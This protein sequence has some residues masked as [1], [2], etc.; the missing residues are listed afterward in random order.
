MF[1]R[2]W[3]A[4][5]IGLALSSAALA[6]PIVIKF[7]LVVSEDTPKGKGALLFQRLVDERLAG[8]VKVEVYANSSLY[9]DADKVEALRNNDIQMI[10][11]PLTKYQQYSPQL[12]LFDLP[13]LFDNLKSVERFQQRATGRKLLRSMEQHNITGLAYWHNGMKQLA[14][15]RVIRA[16]DD[17]QGL[18]F[19][20]QPSPV[21]EAQFNALGATAKAVPFIKVYDALASNALQGTEDAW[22]N[23]YS[24]QLH[25][26][27]SSITESEHGVLDYMLVS[28][29]R[30]W[31]G[32]PHQTR[33]ALEG[34]LE[35]VTFAVNRDAAELNQQAREQIRAAGGTQIITLTAAE[36]DSWRERMRPLW[37]QHE[38]LIGRELIEA[39]QT[40]NRRQRE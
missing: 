15:N 24:M 29:S 11:A 31:Y 13:F 23:L 2:C 40:V 32:I 18:T 17:A 3:M 4:C 7:A 28:N 33:M 37:T 10:A 25:Q 9:G 22:S 36:R 35:E 6:E 38:G 19:R 1:K 20:I 39:A 5:A 34:I 26:L 12:L 8:Q 16:P 21:L 27:Q 30:F 14:S